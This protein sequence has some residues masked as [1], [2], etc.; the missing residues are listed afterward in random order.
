M[1]VHVV[2]ERGLGYPDFNFGTPIGH[3]RARNRTSVYVEDITDIARQPLDILQIS[4]LLFGNAFDRIWKIREWRW[5]HQRNNSEHRVFCDDQ[6]Y[7]RLCRHRW[8]RNAAEV[9]QRHDLR[10]ILARN[11]QR[12][13]SRLAAGADLLIRHYSVHQNVRR[14]IRSEE[15]TSELQL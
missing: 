5:D 13:L 2:V 12:R 10:K 3:V 15:H 11:R 6:H 7:S 4:P 14:S 1:R 8:V 9:L